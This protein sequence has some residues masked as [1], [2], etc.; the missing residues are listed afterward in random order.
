MTRILLQP[1]SGPEATEHYNDT[2]DPGV[3]IQ[4]LAKYLDATLLHKL[5]SLGQ[6]YIKVWGLLP[7]PNN[8]PKAWRDLEENDGVTFYKRGYLYF[9]GRVLD[10][11]HNKEL[12]LV[13]WGTSEDDRTWEYI[14]FLRDGKQMA[15]PF[16]REVLNY[17]ID[18][19]RGTALLRKDQSKSL[20]EYILKHEVSIIDEDQINP[21]ISEETQ[22]I[23]E[24]IIPSL[25]IALSMVAY[26]F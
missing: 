20:T 23:D 2:M 12:A 7:K 24:I 6:P 26:G 1:A 18:Y 10:K 22:L 25:L 3:S 19:V 4:Y 21:S 9:F 11:T 8:A 14:Y 5:K 17:K 15:I 16:K 13:L